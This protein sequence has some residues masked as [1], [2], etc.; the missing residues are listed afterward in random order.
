MLGQKTRRRSLEDII[1]H[2]RGGDSRRAFSAVRVT[3]DEGAGTQEN[4]EVVALDIPGVALAL[5]KEFECT[6]QPSCLR[7][8]CS[9]RGAGDTWC[10]PA[11]V[12]E[13]AGVSV[14]LAYTFNDAADVSG[15]TLR[16]ALCDGNQARVVCPACELHFCAACDHKTHLLPKDHP[17]CSMH[18]HPRIAL[19]VDDTIV[20]EHPPP[21]VI[22]AVPAEYANPVATGPYTMPTN[23]VLWGEYRALALELQ[24]ISLE[25][26]CTIRGGGHHVDLTRGCC[27]S[28]YDRQL[29]ILVRFYM[30]TLKVDR[31]ETTLRKIMD[32]RRGEH[33][34][35]PSS[36][37]VATEL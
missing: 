23:T 29:N 19:H 13:L 31:D 33:A 16:C 18:D 37:N 22:A 35:V 28:R 26:S 11:G 24:E 25:S 21:P 14:R 36:A 9:G 10:A 12:A 15:G 30:L 8:E 7:L 27:F 3:Y 6:L 20:A 34:Y 4:I 32:E 17:H 5:L 1:H 2:R